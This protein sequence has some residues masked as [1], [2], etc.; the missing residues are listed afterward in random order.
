M[1]RQSGSRLERS[2]ALLRPIGLGQLRWPGRTDC[3]PARRVGRAPALA[4]PARIFRRFEFQHAP[5]RTRGPSTGH[6][7]GLETAR[8]ARGDR[9]RRSLRASGHAAALGR[10]GAVHD[11]RAT[12]RGADPFCHRAA[13]RA[14][15]HPRSLG[16]NG[17]ASSR[18]PPR[19]VTRR[20]G[21]CRDLFFPSPLP[22]DRPRGR[23]A[24][25]GET[26]HRTTRTDRDPGDPASAHP[27]AHSRPRTPRLVRASSA[28]RLGFRM[29]QPPCFTRIFL[30]QGCGGHFREAPMP[31][32]RM[33]PTTRSTTPDGFRRRR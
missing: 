12:R 2:T 5:A 18:R 26:P 3:H 32:C 31:Y 11:V 19:L 1:P 25:G 27:V 4:D 15:H 29:G 24:R 33:W 14:G 16:P 13:G 7:F 10:G 22:L 21:L 28:G 23:R 20:G 9:G 17:A 8:A 6:L 30:Q